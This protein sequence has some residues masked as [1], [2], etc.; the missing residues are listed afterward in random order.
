MDL[1]LEPRALGQFLCRALGKEH[2]RRSGCGRGKEPCEAPLRR[3]ITRLSLP[4][5]RL[6]AR[7]LDEHDHVVHGLRRLGTNLHRR[8]PLVFV[9]VRLRVGVL[10]FHH[11]LR[12]HLEGVGGGND[13][14][15]RSD[16]P[17]LYE[18]SGQRCI[19]RVALGRTIVRPRQQVLQVALGQRAIVGPFAGFSVREPRRHAPALRHVLDCRS[20]I[21]YLLVAIERHG[22]VALGAVTALAVLRHETADPVVIRDR[23]LLARH[24]LIGGK[25]AA[26]CVGLPAHDLAPQRH[27]S[28]R[29]TEVVDGRGILVVV[30][31]I[32]VVDRAAVAQCAP[33]VD[34]EGFGR[35]GGTKRIDDFAVPVENRA[36]GK[37]VFRGVCPGVGARVRRHV[38]VGE[39]VALRAELLFE[40]HQPR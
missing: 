38:H 12:R 32:L 16:V 13:C 26:W 4:G 15:G 2:R 31:S 8:D 27:T 1:E 39:G 6:A 9:K 28:E 25:H 19:L 37:L 22:R 34:H 30:D 3:G 36:A 14:V 40:L 33:C 17:P 20:T 5:V 18:L 7:L 29:F 23:A 21:G 35:G 10:V 11:A 24:R